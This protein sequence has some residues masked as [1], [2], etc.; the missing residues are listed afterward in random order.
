MPKLW[1]WV[2]SPDLVERVQK[3]IK[4]NNGRRDALSAY[5]SPEAQGVG[6]PAQ[7]EALRHSF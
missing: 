1:G 7:H 2:N 3:R 5:P 4:K 6:Q